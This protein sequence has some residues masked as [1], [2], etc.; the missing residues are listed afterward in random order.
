MALIVYTGGSTG[1]PKGVMHS[2]FSAN[3]NH[4]HFQMTNAN[5]LTRYYPYERYTSCIPMFLAVSLF[6]CIHSPL[7]QTMELV[8]SPD[9]SPKPVVNMIVRYKPD[10][11]VAS[12]LH[13]DS[14]V[15]YAEDNKF[16]LSFIKSAMYGGEQIDIEW[17]K[18]INTKLNEYNMEGYVQ[19]GYG[20]TETAATVLYRPILGVNGLIPFSDVNVMICDSDAKE[21]ECGYDEVGELCIAANT[22]M[23]GYY[24]NEEETNKTLFE[25]D[26]VLWIKTND[27][28]QISKDGIVTITGRIK[29]IYWKKAQDSVLRIYP[30]QIE[31]TLN[32]SN[33]VA[34]SAVVGIKDDESGYRTYAYLVLNDK[35]ANKEDVR[36]ELEIL[37]NEELPESHFPDEYRFIGDFPYTRSGKIDYKALEKMSEKE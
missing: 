4:V 22:L 10:H 28:A 29:R 18:Q 30:M 13:Y 25:K 37:C 17:E 33:H 14:L 32:K 2:N 15:K 16:D 11:V 6:P 23:M 7:C 35:R 31:D 34:R 21:K 27:L 1:I 20:M 26:G 8:I 36:E 5:G 24:K 12:R 3:N 19:N 9:P